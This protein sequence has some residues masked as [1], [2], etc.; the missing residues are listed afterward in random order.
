[1]VY[2]MNRE[3]IRLKDV[4]EERYNR[5]VE[6]TLQILNSFTPERQTMGLTD[7]SEAINLSKATV[8][9]LASTLCKH[10]FLNQDHQSRRYSLGVKLFDWAALSII[11]FR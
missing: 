11:L 2:L 3:R 4:G 8:L 9:R 7:L 10:G 1:M 5:S 6:R